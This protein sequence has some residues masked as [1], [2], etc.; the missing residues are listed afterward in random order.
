MLS[1]VGPK[2]LNNDIA[3]PIDMK[4]L[5]KLSQNIDSEKDKKKK[6]Q[7]YPNNQYESYLECDRIYFKQLIFNNSKHPLRPFWIVSNYSEVTKLAFC[8]WKRSDNYCRISSDYNYVDI[9]DG[10]IDSACSNPCTT[11]Q[12]LYFFFLFCIHTNHIIL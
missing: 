6:C 12:V 8:D 5:I 4:V 2:F 7:S 1:Y 10:T 3:I 11:F 9:F